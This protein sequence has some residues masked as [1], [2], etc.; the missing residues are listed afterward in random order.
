VCWQPTFGH[1]AEHERS[2]PDHSSSAIYQSYK[3]VPINALVLTNPIN[4]RFV[5]Q[6]EA[7]Q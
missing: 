1:L 7:I 5:G 4:S 2:K 6:P 3:S